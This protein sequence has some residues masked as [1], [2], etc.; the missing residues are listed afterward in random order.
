[1]KGITYE[2]VVE[3]GCVH[4]AVGVSLPEKAK[5][6]VVVP[7]GDGSGVGRAIRIPSPRLLHR[8]QAID[9]IKEVY[10]VEGDA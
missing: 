1:M 9:F 10:E 3:N 5:V 7:D 4:V 2:G 6:F 8:E